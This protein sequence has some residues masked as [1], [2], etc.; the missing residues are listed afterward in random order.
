MMNVIEI[1]MKRRSPD[2]TKEI[3]HKFVLTKD[4][5]QKI[6]DTSVYGLDVETKIMEKIRTE[7]AMFMCLQAGEVIKEELAKLPPDLSQGHERMTKNRDNE[8]LELKKKLVIAVGDLT[9]IRETAIWSH[10]EGNYEYTVNKIE[11]L[12]NK[13][14]EDIPLEDIT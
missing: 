6:V 7:L 11:H 5:H 3:N 8:I 10:A 2:G 4:E 1:D 14:I 12:A 9:E 13:A